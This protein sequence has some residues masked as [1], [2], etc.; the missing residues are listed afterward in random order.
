MLFGSS[1][2][3]KTT[4]LRAIAGFFR[5]KDGRISLEIEGHPSTLLDT[6]EGVFVPPHLR[7]IRSATQ[8]ARLF[9]HRTVRENIAYGVRTGL[10]SEALIDDVLRRFKIE[11]LADRSPRELSGGETQRAATARAVVSASQIPGSLLLL[12]EPFSG[13]ELSL[14]DW[15]LLDLRAWLA[16]TGVRVLSVTHEIHEPFRLNAEVIRIGD[17]RVLDQGS[18]QQVLAKERTRLLSSL[19]NP[20]LRF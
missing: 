13:L 12:D 5:P 16:E 4:I 8:S 17:G 15:L 20:E 9:P 3:G 1:G 11:S 7:P 18:P 2:S 14:R 6:K 10:D 19:D